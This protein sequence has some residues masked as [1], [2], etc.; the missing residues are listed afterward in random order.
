MVF[1]GIVETTGTIISVFPINAKDG[2]DAGIT[3]VVKPTSLFFFDS[4]ISI[5]CSIAVNGTCVTVTS[6]DNEVRQFCVLLSFVYRHFKSI[7]HP[8]HFD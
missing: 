8:K 2:I 7:W 5:G 3:L 6:F 1:S 4:D